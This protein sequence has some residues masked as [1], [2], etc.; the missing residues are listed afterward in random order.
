MEQKMDDGLWC[1]HLVG[2]DDVWA[3]PSKAAAEAE[4]ARTNEAIAIEDAKHVGDPHWPH[5]RAIVIPWPYSA[6]RHAEELAKARA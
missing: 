1:V 4:A 5:A 3:M 6:D 2:P